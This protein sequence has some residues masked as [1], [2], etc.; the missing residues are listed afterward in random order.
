[1]IE[2]GP[3]F[4]ALRPFKV[5]GHY[6]ST[7]DISNNVLEGKFFEGNYLASELW[8]ARSRLEP[9]AEDLCDLAARN[10]R[11]LIE[12]VFYALH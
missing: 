8:A 12:K 1:M 6:L 9:P 7:L 3:A 4:A 2:G 5:D 10:A 11:T